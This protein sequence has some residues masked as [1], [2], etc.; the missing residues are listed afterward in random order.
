MTQSGSFGNLS[1]PALVSL[2]G[3]DSSIVD[4]VATSARANAANFEWDVL[5]FLAELNK[6]VELMAHVGHRFNHLTETMA[7]EA[8]NWKNPYKRFRQLWLASRYGIRPM[9]YDYLNAAQALSN[10]I[11]GSNIIKGRG[12]HS[13]SDTLSATKVVNAAGPGTQV[14]V[15]TQTDTLQYTRQYRSVVYMELGG[16]GKN[17]FG[18][19]P[20]VT[21][22]ELVPYSFV[23]D[24]F[25][26]I[27]QWVSTLRPSLLGA[28]LGQQISIKTESHY[29]LNWSNV[30]SGKPSP[31][32]TI[33]GSGS[34]LSYDI[35]TREYVRY[36]YTGTPLPTFR[37]R[38][39]LPKLV[40][41]VTLFVRGERRVYRILSKR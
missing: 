3:I 7:L 1:L 21:A 5:T 37:P 35:Q 6:S 11:G 29:Q 9:M 23:L 8:R 33:T 34:G 10:H 26:N 27:G 39:T 25:F 32:T 14:D 20:L 17:R 18:V 12:F 16:T 30:V 24:W 40:D 41:L 38:L 31:T 19:D 4:L 28:W 15:N 22:W 2:P 13:V 36:A